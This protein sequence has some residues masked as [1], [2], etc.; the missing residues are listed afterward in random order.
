ME[1]EEELSHELPPKKAAKYYAG[2]VN[3]L[4]IRTRLA[5]FPLAAILWVSLGLPAFGALGTGLKVTSLACLVMQLCIVMLG[6]DVFTAG[7]MSLVRGRPGMWSLAAV[8]NIAAA[9]DAAVGLRRRHG[10]LGL[11]HVR[12]RRAGHVLRA[13]GRAAGGQ[14]AALFQ[15]GP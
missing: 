10:R 4:R 14:G 9:L 3:S 5:L 13:L 2:S 15:Q 11:P 1:D 6:L 12:R 7:I 8:A